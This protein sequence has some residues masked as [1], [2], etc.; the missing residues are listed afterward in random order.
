MKNFIMLILFLVFFA[1]CAE[2]SV[3]KNEESSIN[4]DS[5]SNSEDPSTNNSIEQEYIER[6]YASTLYIIP[7]FNFF[8]IDKDTS[9]IVDYTET[10]DYS[11]NIYKN[12]NY[13]WVYEATLFTR[14]SNFRL[15]KAKN[16]NIFIIIPLDSVYPS[17]FEVFDY[18]T[19]TFLYTHNLNENIFPYS[20]NIASDG[21]KIF[22]ATVESDKLLLIENINNEWIENE[23][24][25]NDNITTFVYFKYS[26]NYILI[27]YY[28]NLGTFTKLFKFESNY[29]L[30]EVLDITGEI[31]INTGF[32]YEIILNDTLLSFVSTKNSNGTKIISTY[33]NDNFT[34]W[35]KLDDF[36]FDNLNSYSFAMRDFRDS[37]FIGYY[38][39]DKKQIINSFY[40]KDSNSQALI[41]TKEEILYNETLPTPYFNIVDYDVNNY[42]LNLSILYTTNSGPKKLR[43]VS[44]KIIESINYGGLTTKDILT[45]NNDHSIISYTYTSFSNNRALMVDKENNIYKLNLYKSINGSWVKVN[46][47]FTSEKLFFIIKA[48]NAD[49]FILYSSYSSLSQEF[50]IYEPYKELISF[51]ISNMLTNRASK[52]AISEDG[53]RIIY[54]VYDNIK[55][56]LYIMD[57]QEDDTWIINELK[58][59]PPVKFNLGIKFSNNY[60]F[61]RYALSPTLE[62][63][64][65]VFYID[66]NYNLIE[67]LE[68]LNSDLIHSSRDWHL[69]VVISDSFFAFISFYSF[70]EVS[71]R[72]FKNIDGSFV[73]T[74]GFSYKDDKTF[75]LNRYLDFYQDFLVFN[76][77]ILNLK[78]PYSPYEINFEIFEYKNNAF[79]LKFKYSIE[80]KADVQVDPVQK[81]N[82]SYSLNKDGVSYCGVYG[83]MTPGKLYRNICYTDFNIYKDLF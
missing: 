80:D 35:S 63:Y 82:F 57:R 5:S 49:T 46:T 54:T 18:D 61:L 40:S 43:L 24:Y 2:K 52:P 4:K 30:T 70:I 21:S 64:N 53:N 41:K 37:L 39:K 20:L 44:A 81:H 34:G 32:F 3:L 15:L 22:Y 25:F 59:L 42:H 27:K 72:V 60:V 69:D 83:P 65:K 11:F 56:E 79:D 26:D 47:L 16:A 67:K 74:Q 75:F 31:A 23:L 77:Y 62:T 68:V 19:N 9:L 50:Y 14:E 36:Y 58:G 7:G 17:K 6:R 71:I 28:N 73:E 48:K 33:F 13:N 45:Y 38:D 78:L 76:T 12:N 10:N 66:E 29:E 8:S 51:D 1:S 55:S